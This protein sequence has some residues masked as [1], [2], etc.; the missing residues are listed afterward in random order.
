VRRSAALLVVVAAVSVVAANTGAGA[1]SAPA[2]CDG[3]VTRGVIPSWARAGFSEARPVMTYELSQDGQ[4][5]ALIFGFPLTA[6]PR[7]AINNKIL[8]VSRPRPV[9][10]V[11]SLRLRAQRMIG[12]RRVG[13]VVTH[14]V[15][16]GPNPSIIDLPAPG[17]W[18]VNATWWG[19]HDRIDL[20]YTP[21]ALT[22][23]TAR[24]G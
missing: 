24:R 11:G 9:G 6:P 21:R 4:L 22:S 7:A 19:H 20:R 12:T 16:G 23:R 14:Y 18:R 1:A 8:W 13:A 17:C 5:A 10:A 15:T 3:S 2:A